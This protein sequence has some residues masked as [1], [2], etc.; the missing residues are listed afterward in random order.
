MPESPARTIDALLTLGSAYG[1][2][3]LPVQIEQKPTAG[4]TLLF[5]FLS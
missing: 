5:L 4:T 2:V 3:Y 1:F